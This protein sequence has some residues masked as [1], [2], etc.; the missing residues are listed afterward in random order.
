MFYVCH[1]FASVHCCLV[2]TWR[3]LANLLALVFDVNCDFVTVPFGILGQVRY[4]IVSI[5]DP[6]CLS[7]FY[8]YFHFLKGPFPRFIIVFVWLIWSFRPSQ[9]FSV[10]SGRIFLSWT[11]RSTKQWLMCFAQWYNAIRLRRWDLTP[12]PL[13][14]NSS[15]LSLS[16]CAPINYCML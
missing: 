2:V 11:S 13:H 3:D 9:Q 15:N 16:H 6:C 8:R 10:M 14:L 5:P 12:Q 1:A 4:L 7:N